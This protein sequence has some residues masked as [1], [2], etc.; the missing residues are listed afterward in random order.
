MDAKVMVEKTGKNFSEMMS[1][2]NNTENKTV[3]NK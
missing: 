2:F 3:R 1:F